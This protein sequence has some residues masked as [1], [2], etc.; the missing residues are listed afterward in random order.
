MGVAA[1]A[2]WLLLPG[3]P[4]DDRSATVDVANTAVSAPADDSRR[5]LESAV[6]SGLQDVAT[7]GKDAQFVAL[8]L[9]STKPAETPEQLKARLDALASDSAA[10]RAHNEDVY[11][12]VAVTETGRGRSPEAQS[13]RALESIVA[14]STQD[15]PAR[16]AGF[17]GAIGTEAKAQEDAMR[18]IVVQAGDT[19]S[20]I[21]KRAYGDPEAF[22]RIFEANP[23][24]LA[25]PHHIFPGQVLRVP[26]AA[27]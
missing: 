15:R 2:A 17:V 10:L 5:A 8:Q 24:V 23:R 27:R 19:L 9:A 7:S 4:S 21:A 18:T 26:G 22:G 16:L 6:Q 14:L 11:N 1:V 20:A 25:S 12:K 3:R 13:R